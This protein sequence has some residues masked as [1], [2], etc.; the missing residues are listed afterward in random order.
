MLSGVWEIL[1]VMLPWESFSEGHIEPTATLHD[2]DDDDDDDDEEEEEEEEDKGEE[3]FINKKTYLAF[4]CRWPKQH[5]YSVYYQHLQWFFC[6]N[7]T[8]MVSLPRHQRSGLFSHLAILVH[9]LC[10]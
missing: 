4:S 3:D 6:P 9:H 1:S 10:W 8:Y 7:D 2:D 5:G